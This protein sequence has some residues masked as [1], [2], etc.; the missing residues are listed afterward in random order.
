MSDCTRCGS[1]KKVRATGPRYSVA[2]PRP[3]S[4]EDAIIQMRSRLVVQ[5]NEVDFSFFPGQVSTLAY[6]IIYAV[7]LVDRNAVI[8]L[9]TAQKIDFIEKYPD[10]GAY[11]L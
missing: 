3:V 1:K 10:T 4:G 5:I 8:F 11:P 6:P 7:L 9:N 2:T